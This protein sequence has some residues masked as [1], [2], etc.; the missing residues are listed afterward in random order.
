MYLLNR[1]GIYYYQ[2]VT[3]CNGRR[4]TFR[5][6]LKTRDKAQAQLLALQIHFNHSSPDVQQAVCISDA[7]CR[8]VMSKPVGFE[9]EASTTQ[10]PPL[11]GHVHIPTSTSSEAVCPSGVESPAVPSEHN[12]N[13][14]DQEDKLSGHVESYIAE[15]QLSWAPKETKNQQNYI[16]TFIEHVGDKGLSEYTKAD[17]VSFKTWLLGSGKSPTTINKYIQKLSLLF[18]WL[19]DHTEQT[20]DIFKGL[21]LKRVKEVNVRTGYT[22]PELKLFD[23]W[24]KEQ[25]PWRMFIAMIGRYHGLRSNEACQLYSDDIEH[26]NGVCCFNIRATRDDQSLKT[27]ASQ[28]LVPIHS[29]LLGAGFLDFVASRKGGRLFK[30]LPYRNNCYS[31][32]FG[33][34]FS[35]NRPVN[36][37]FHSLRHTVASKLKAAGIP[38]QYAAAILG[39]TNKAISYDRYGGDVPLD[40]LKEAL[41]IAL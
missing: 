24:A 20:T 6:S 25:E 32:L 10:H 15:K 29:K 41:E 9:A 27:E 14:P 23:S 30:E 11:N 2:R 37:D 8:D 39:H 1:N 13:A 26:V 40:K 33:Q 36:K 12:Q 17:A 4:Q 21:K 34:W 22:D 16:N 28:R 7:A 5:K 38:L 3:M 31:H 19:S 18:S 35:R